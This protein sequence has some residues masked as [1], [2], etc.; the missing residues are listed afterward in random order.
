M[1]E[2]LQSEGANSQIVDI[3]V[4]YF[5]KAKGSRHNNPSEVLGNDGLIDQV[6]GQQFNAAV[7]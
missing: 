6:T 4:N 3:A 1:K 2:D 7:R 5:L